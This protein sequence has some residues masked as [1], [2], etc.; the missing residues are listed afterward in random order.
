MATAPGSP[1]TRAAAGFTLVEILVVIVIIGVI[2]SA[3]TLA[4]GVLGRDRQVED[5]SRRFWAVLQ[6]ARE[7]AELQSLDVAVFVAAGEY[8]FLRYD[9]RREEWLSIVDD[10]LYAQRTLPEGLR[11]RLWV[12]GREVVLKPD[13][14]NR[15]D[16]D[17]HKKW[18]PQIMVLSSGE[19]M[20][21]ELH[22]ERD[23]APAL[24]RVVA[25]ADNDLRVE[26]RDD[27]REWVMIA[28]T[29]QPPP[30]EREKERLSNA[31]R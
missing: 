11:F 23:A 5:E 22:V 3:S 14:P 1:W 26:R 4:V 17:E 7:E 29:K 21:F 25:L 8:E 30:D 28:Q 12:D 20:P 9:R 18:P 31:R 10:R 16:K 24:W 15:G 6:Q 2:V 19:L 27:Q 13:L